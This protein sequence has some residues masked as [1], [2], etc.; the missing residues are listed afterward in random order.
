MGRFRFYGEGRIFKWQSWRLCKERKKATKDEDL[1]E[2]GWYHDG[3]N[4]RRGITSPFPPPKQPKFITERLSILA[5]FR[6]NPY[7]Y[8]NFMVPVQKILVHESKVYKIV[9]INVKVYH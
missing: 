1:N 4:S 5:I 7:L 2:T 6:F 8:F 9:F 3:I